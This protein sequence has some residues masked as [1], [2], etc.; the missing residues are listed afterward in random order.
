M[1]HMTE[2]KDT[3]L[4]RS[5][6]TTAHEPSQNTVVVDQN[7]QI[8]QIFSWKKTKII[9]EKTLW[10]LSNN[11]SWKNQGADAEVPHLFTDHLQ[12]RQTS[13]TSK[14]KAVA[15]NGY[16]GQVTEWG[17]HCPQKQ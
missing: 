4:V 12:A 5:F 15:T 14:W 13:R 8:F 6:S 10:C 1:R 7:I 16:K 2:L 9:S 3:I 11:K 17:N